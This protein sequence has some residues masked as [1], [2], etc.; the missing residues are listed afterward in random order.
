MPEP[1]LETII[2]HS[3]KRRMEGKRICIT[4]HD[5]DHFT[6][7]VKYLTIGALRCI[8]FSNAI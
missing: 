2:S 4:R 6:I 7:I 8:G 3:E 1:P 5:D